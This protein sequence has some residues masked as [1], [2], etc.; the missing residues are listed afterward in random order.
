MESQRVGVL[1]KAQLRWLLGQHP[2][3]SLGAW[4]LYLVQVDVL[5]PKP[6]SYTL[7][8]EF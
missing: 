5:N 6:D 1:K 4:I 8:P 7:N 2:Q 3:G